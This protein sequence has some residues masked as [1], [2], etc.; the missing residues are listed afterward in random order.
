[1][2]HEVHY[3][4]S[5]LLRRSIITQVSRFL[6]LL[7]CCWDPFFLWYILRR[8]ILFK[9]I[10]CILFLCYSLAKVCKK[11]LPLQSMLEFDPDKRISAIEALHHPYFDNSSYKTDRS[12]L[13]EDMQHSGQPSVS[14]TPS[15]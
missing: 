11:C 8:F 15:L 14:P 3:K 4:S 7:F 10:Y 12:D 2:A 5:L 1:M 9:L 13:I 6:F